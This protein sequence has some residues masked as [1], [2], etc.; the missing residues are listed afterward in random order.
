MYTQNIASALRLVTTGGRRRLIALVAGPLAGLA[1]TLGTAAPSAAADTTFFGGNAV[2]ISAN[3]KAPPVVAT[4]GRAALGLGGCDGTD[5]E[6]RSNT[7]ASV[8]VGTTLTPG[9]ITPTAFTSRA[10]GTARLRNTATVSSLNLLGGLITA[11]TLEAVAG[12]SA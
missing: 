3:A 4:L 10:G 5:G 1:I 12:L 2:G 7:V 6:T 8:S 11:T 9:L